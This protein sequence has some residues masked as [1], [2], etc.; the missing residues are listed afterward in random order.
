MIYLIGL[1]FLMTGCDSSPQSTGN[2]A[3]QSPKESTFSIVIDF[4]D[5][6][7]DAI[8]S[9]I[10]TKNQISVIDLLVAASQKAGF[11]I[12]HRGSGET[13]FVEAID[14]VKGG[15]DGKNWWMYYVNDKLAKQGSGVYQLK[16]GDRVRWSLGKYDFSE[17]VETSK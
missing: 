9:K 7:K 5:Y 10:T 8:E 11:P 12:E 3:P 16:S 17:D 14:G 6:E 4:G 15:E 1:L 2:M 13:A